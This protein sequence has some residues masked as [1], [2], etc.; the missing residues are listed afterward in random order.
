MSTFLSIRWGT[1]HFGKADLNQGGTPSLIL[2]R[3]S[4]GHC[5]KCGLDPSLHSHQVELQ[6][7]EMHSH[8]AFQF[9]KASLALFNFSCQGGDLAVHWCKAFLNSGCSLKNH[10]KSSRLIFA[11]HRLKVKAL[12][13]LRALLLSHSPSNIRA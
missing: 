12:K 2:A 6:H 11:C 1:C 10:F 3:Y 8:P 4:T 13:C 7:R 5:Q 9:K